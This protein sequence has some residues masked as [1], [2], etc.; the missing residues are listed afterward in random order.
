MAQSPTGVRPETLAAQALGWV[1]TATKAIVP[2]VHPATTYERDLNNPKAKG[3]VYSRDENP[4]YEQPEA[5][6]NALEGGAGCMLFASGM[7]AAASVFQALRVGDHVVLPEIFYWGG[8]GIAKEMTAAWGIEADFVAN[9]DIAALS[10]VVRQGQT[11]IVWIETPL[12]PALDIADI[13]A[14]AQVAHE[15]GS[16]LVVDSTLATP[17]LTRPIEHGADIVMHSATK[18]L[19]GHSD[20]VAGALVTAKAD[21]FWIRIRAVRIYGGAVPGPFEAWL[22]LRGM[23]TL[24]LRVRAQSDSAAA[25]AEHFSDHPR[26]SRVFYP[27]LPSHPDHEIAVRQMSGGFGGV[28][29]IQLMGG[30]TASIR[31]WK[32]VQVWKAATS[33][34][35]IES[36][37]ER[38]ASLETSDRAAPDDLL[39][40]SVGIEHVDDLIADLQQALEAG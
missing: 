2:A 1:D 15:A 37:I 6:L 9:G 35:G 3:R 14:T 38:P 32:A 22:L 20:V 25:I 7:A 40:L 36:L 29:S 11:K 27:G 24:L 18:Y 19:N 28:L 26:I 13:A 30:E 21:L 31:T 34:G 10:R 4:T 16:R 12:N 23:R 17:V 8:R 33:F 39:R 5:L